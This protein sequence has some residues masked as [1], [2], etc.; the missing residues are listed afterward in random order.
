M[1]KSF[2]S[3]TSPSL[4]LST[5]YDFLSTSESDPIPEHRAWGTIEYLSTNDVESKQ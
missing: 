5:S 1:V 2:A 4:I 3:H